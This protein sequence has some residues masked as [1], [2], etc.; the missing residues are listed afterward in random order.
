M[1]KVIAKEVDCGAVQTML[2]SERTVDDRKNMMLKPLCF[3]FDAVEIIAY[4]SSFTYRK[5]EPSS[6][7]SHR[8]H[9]EIRLPVQA[10]PP[11]RLAG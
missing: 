3:D 9:I 2:A 1:L 10:E 6:F 5:M 4:G 7:R 8:N 11:R